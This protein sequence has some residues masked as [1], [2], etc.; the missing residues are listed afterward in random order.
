MLRSKLPY[1]VRLLDDE[2]PE[3][4]TA[5][6][7]ALESFGESLDREL[8]G[9]GIALSREE[10]A[11]IQHL[12]DRCRRMAVR[13]SW[14][15]WFSL[16]DDKRRLE[17]AMALIVELQDGAA[18]AGRLEVLLDQCATEFRSGKHNHDA[19]ALARF[20]FKEKQLR[21]VSQEKY[22]NPLNSNLVYVL[23]EKRGLPISLSCV[24]MLV[25]KRVGL[26]IEGCNFPGHFLS[27]AHTERSRVL[28]DC[29]NGGRTIGEDDLA[30]ID[31][32]VSLKEILRL[33]CRSAAIIARV[34]R[35]L[36]SAYEHT[37]DT[38]NLRLM[39]ELLDMMKDER[40][41]SALA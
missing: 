33:E 6:L 40:T 11:P 20:L 41:M 12:L 32:R 23:E 13:K 19:L 26:P 1:L 39:D 2:T 21:G 36:K 22:L 38:D 16:R 15:A 27:I 35:N 34:L 37:R 3:V 9:C 7:Q 4:R 17:A 10:S 8:Q 25:G 18:A 29:Y 31:S 14:P 24:Y 5:V 28:V 30:S